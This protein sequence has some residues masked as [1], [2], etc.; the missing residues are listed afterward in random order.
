MKKLLFALCLGLT[1]SL[2]AC[3]G[4]LGLGGVGN[5]IDLSQTTTDE[6]ALYVAES[7]FTAASGAIG[8]AIDA[9]QLKGQRA[10]VVQKYYR[11]ARVALDLAKSAQ[12]VGDAATVLEKA[13]EAQKL[14]AEVFEHFQ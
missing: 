2:A 6:K 9:G 5:A 4:S 14:I 13:T 8:E 7:A 12:E 10:V 11:Q 3:N 1:A